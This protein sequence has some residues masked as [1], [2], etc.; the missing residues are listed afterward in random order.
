MMTRAD[1]HNNPTAFT[2]DLARQAGLME[3]VNYI[4]GDSFAVPNSNL[5]LYTAML[6]GDPIPLTI[7][8]IN[9]CGFFTAAGLQRWSYI[10]MR[11]AIWN[12][13]STDAKTQIIHGMYREE[14]G[15]QLEHLFNIAG[16]GLNP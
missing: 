6:I 4:Q 14:T 16:T 7:R 12:L 8:V 1:R 11:K 15:T 9:A 10:G 5:V 3:S 13:L 2:T